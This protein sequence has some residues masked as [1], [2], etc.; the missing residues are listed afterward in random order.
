MASVKADRVACKV[1]VRW[2]LRQQMLQA[3][4]SSR[5]MDGLGRKVGEAMPD[6]VMTLM[7]LALQ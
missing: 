7:K 5:R 1:E 4:S 3:P 6:E 2:E